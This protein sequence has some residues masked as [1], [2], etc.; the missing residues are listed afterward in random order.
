MKVL[1]LF[2]AFV[3]LICGIRAISAQE[4]C[5]GSD[6]YSTKNCS[7]DDS[8]KDEIELLRLINEYRKQNNL[9]EV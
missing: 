5:A 7:G 2:A 6:V 4:K 9:P 8:T 1:I 3:F